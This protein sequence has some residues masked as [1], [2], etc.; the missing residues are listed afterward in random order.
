MLSWYSPN[1]PIRHSTIYNGGAGVSQ[2]V[3]VNSNHWD[4]DQVMRQLIGLPSLNLAL[5]SSVTAGGKGFELPSSFLS[6]LGE[7]VERMSGAFAFLKEDLGVCAGSYS[8]LQGAGQ[9]AI[10]PEELPLFADEQYAS[11]NFF[12]QPFTHETEF[13][14]VKGRRLISQEDVWIPLQLALLF[15]IPSIEEARIGYSS[16]S[17]MASHIDEALAIIAGVTEIVERD[18]LML[19]WYANIPLRRVEVDRPLYSKKANRALEHIKSLSGDVSFWLHD[20]GFLEL[21]CISAIQLV[22]YYKKFAYQAGTASSLDG[23]EAFIQALMEYGQSEV[24]LK[25]AMLAPKRQFRRGVEMVFDASPDKPLAEMHTFLETIGYYGYAENIGLLKDFFQSNDT[26]GL[27]ELPQI[28]FRHSEEQLEYLKDVLRQYD[29]DPIVIDCTH[30]QMSQV[31]AI[32]VFIPELIQPHISAYP[33][34]GHPRIYELPMKMGLRDKP[35][36][37]KDLKLGPV[38]FP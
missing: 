12:F 16:S 32:K 20:V 27:S 14:W 5:N 18:A 22:P 26:V 29:I 6:D 10:A 13:N 24:Q 38:P 4:T 35:L 33:Y 34:L 15:Y 9:N 36:T 2:T 19:S 1:G 11:P 31:K 8:S 7:S 30:E 17:G 25:C 28:K 37:F 23:E 3:V 21:P